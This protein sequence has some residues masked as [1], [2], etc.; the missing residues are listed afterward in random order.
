MREAIAEKPSIEYLDGQAYPKVSPRLAHGVVQG[1]LTIVLTRCAGERG[2]VGPELH[3]YPGRVDQTKTVF[4][5]DV[6]FVSWERIDSSSIER[7]EPR[8]PDVAVEVRSPSNDLHYLEKKIARYLATGSILV[9][10]VDPKRRVIHAHDSDGTRRFDTGERFRRAC[11]P[12]LT[13]D[14]AEVFANLDRISQADLAD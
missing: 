7:E 8:S 14:V 3:V 11:L 1:N 2:I 4:V 10:D 6:S 12:W 5:P 13:F 9:L